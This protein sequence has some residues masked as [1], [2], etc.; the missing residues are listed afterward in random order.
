[1]IRHGETV[2]TVGRAGTVTA[3]QGRQ[4]IERTVACLTA[5]FL[6]LVPCMESTGIGVYFVE[7]R[8]TQDGLR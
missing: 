8:L 7:E 1:M 5:R 4:C 3:G 6:R 2:G